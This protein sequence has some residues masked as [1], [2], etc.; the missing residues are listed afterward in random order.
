VFHVV[1][2]VNGD[3]HGVNQF[4]FVNAEHVFFEVRTE[5]LNIDKNGFVLKV[6]LKLRRSI[7][8]NFVCEQSSCVADSDTSSCS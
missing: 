4:V 8:M 5:F 6:L 7:T 3:Y 1:L 2:I